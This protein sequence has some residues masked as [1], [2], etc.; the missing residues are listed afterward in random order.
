MRIISKNLPAL[1]KF[2]TIAAFSALLGACHDD[3]RDI[4]GVLRHEIAT[5]WASAMSPAA[6]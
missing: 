5:C 1:H 4:G 3:A 2:L 6:S